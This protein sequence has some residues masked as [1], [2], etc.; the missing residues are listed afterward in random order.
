VISGLDWAKAKQ[1]SSS[2]NKASRRMDSPSR[3]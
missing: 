3:K 1:G 2:K